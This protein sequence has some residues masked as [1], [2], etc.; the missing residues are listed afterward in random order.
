MSG[1]PQ[2]D[3]SDDVVRIVEVAPRD[4]LQNEPVTLSTADKIRLIEQVVAAGAREVEAVSFVR[5]D[6]VPA[7]A[8]AEAVLSGIDRIDA[9]F[10]ALVLNMRGVARAE[11]AKVPEINAV[12]VAT[13]TFSRRNQNC[14]TSEGVQRWHEMS[15]AARKAG[16]RPVVT[17][18]AAFGCPFEGEVSISRIAD[19]AAAAC[20]AGPASLVLADTIGVGAPGDVLSRLRAVRGSIPAE[21]E[22]RCH[23]HNTRNTGLA[24]VWAALEAG[25][26]SFDASVGGIGGCPFAPKATGNIPTEDVVYMLHRSGLRT[27]LDPEALGSVVPWLEDRLGHPAPGLLSKA[28]MFP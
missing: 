3:V 18:A 23:F 4:G 27:G 11:A 22:L 8:D 20:E 2:F 1:P 10:S 21:V 15:G 5:P 14:S 13:D 26:R 7:M 25:V 16:I 12:V 17:I 9:R 28:G 6:A 24:N 19:L